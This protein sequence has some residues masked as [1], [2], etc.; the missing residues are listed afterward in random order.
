VA[1][2]VAPLTGGRI[3][4]AGTTSLVRL[5]DGSSNYA[6]ATLYDANLGTAVP[7]VAQA[8]GRPATFDFRGLA[9]GDYYIELSDDNGA[10][11]VQ[12]QI[13]SVACTPWVCDLA[14]DA[15][16]TVI[17]NNTVAGATVSTGPGYGLG[18]G[19]I[20]VKAT[21][22]AGGVQYSL[23]GISYQS[24]PVAGGPIRLGLSPQGAPFIGLAAGTYNVFAIDAAGCVVRTTLDI[25]DDIPCNVSVQVET[26]EDTAYIRNIGGNRLEYD[27][28]DGRGFGDWRFRS[29][30]APRIYQVTAREVENHAC[31]ETVDFEVFPYQTNPRL[32]C[33][34]FLTIG[35]EW[36]NI[37]E[38]TG[39]DAQE[40][41]I[42]RDQ[43]RHGVSFEY[44]DQTLGF[45]CDAGFNLIDAQYALYGPDVEIGFIELKRDPLNPPLLRVVYKGRLDLYGAENTGGEWLVDV[46]GDGLQTL[47]VARLKT[48]LDLLGTK[49]LD[50]N[51]LTPAAAPTQ[52][53][54]LHSKAIMKV[55]HNTAAPVFASTGEIDRGTGQ[56]VQVLILGFNVPVV[57]DLTDMFSQNTGFLLSTNIVPQQPTYPFHVP[58]E[59]GP[60][61]IEFLVK[62]W[63][64]IQHNS[65]DDNF[66]G[67]FKLFYRVNNEPPELLFSC[68]GI[69]TPSTPFSTD[70]FNG[71][72]GLNLRA[73]RTRPNAVIG[74]RFYLYGVCNVY[75]DPNGSDY[76]Y[77]YQVLLDQTSFVK[78]T[79]QTVAPDSTAQ[80]L[81]VYEALDRGLQVALGRPGLLRSTL[82]GRTDSSPRT[83]PTL[84]DAGLFAVLSGLMLRGIGG[85]PFA[86]SLDDMLNGLDSPFCVG[87][88]VELDA[89]GA[90]T[91]RIE[92]AEEFYAGI[93]ALV[94]PDCENFTRKV[95]A[96]RQAN[97]VNIGF[98][99]WQPEGRVENALDE[100]AARRQYST[101]VRLNQVEYKRY[102][103]FIAGGYLLEAQRRVGLSSDDGKNDND[104]FIISVLTAPLQRNIL[105][106]GYFGRSAIVVL[107]NYLDLPAGRTIEIVNGPNAGT[108]VVDSAEAAYSGGP[109]GQSSTAIFLTTALPN[110]GASP[111]NTQVVLGQVLQARRNEGFTVVQNLYSPATAYNLVLTPG[112]ML[113]RHARFLNGHTYFKQPAE[114]YRP[115]F[116]EGNQ[117]LVTRL[118]GE[119]AALDE[120]APVQRQNLAPLA[121]TVFV[122][123]IISFDS[124]LNQDGFDQLRAKRHGYI[125]VYDAETD[126]WYMGYILTVKWKRKDNFAK[127]E[128]LRRPGTYNPT[129]GA[130]Q[131]REYNPTEHNFTEYN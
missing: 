64:K 30:L 49:D 12:S 61:E 23:T 80:A 101:P 68:L 112:R 73:T 44:G 123:E 20:T 76:S 78:V 48:A 66:D 118:T 81:L 87:M 17:E 111:Q 63:V 97:L 47:L 105:E 4:G 109:Q 36:F 58:T 19:A 102:S 106:F 98:D 110:I 42:K 27:W 31:S 41:V 46:E 9:D 50:G 34:Y 67:E 32:C 33:L 45:D 14:F 24:A 51:Q 29:G 53:T 18:T 117:L 114:L 57:Q 113:R 75:G 13:L 70:Q 39:L 65:G 2:E 60:L 40:L 108:Y 124:F 3:R 89:S 79:A 8:V 120:A 38:P 21:S 83:Y 122:P 103:K 128:L 43:V 11:L 86:P 127:F 115:T 55:G 25:I 125:A 22:S 5:A 62:G 52:I 119:A 85:K 99:K 96:T 1:C 107:G 54:R 69:S 59:D 35:G 116:A 37:G 56:N 93:L 28:N 6:A 94:V 10:P 92:K 7:G 100:V 74:D 26:I 126:A 95:D 131:L 129:P 72:L 77:D 91:V 16:A 121:E 15:T 130:Q 84:G 104:T 71:G 82:F 90:D 88:V